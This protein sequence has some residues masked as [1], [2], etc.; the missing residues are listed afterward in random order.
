LAR[1][2]AHGQPG[3]RSSLGSTLVSVTKRANC[4]LSF[5]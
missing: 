4:F 2:G 1:F 5:A 3:A